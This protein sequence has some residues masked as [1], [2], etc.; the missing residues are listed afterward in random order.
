MDAS[1]WESVP[2]NGSEAVPKGSAVNPTTVILTGAIFSLGEGPF[3]EG[4]TQAAVR[5]IGDAIANPTS[6]GRI[7]QECMQ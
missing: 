7:D 1:G 5:A 6:G 4:I 3:R 2:A